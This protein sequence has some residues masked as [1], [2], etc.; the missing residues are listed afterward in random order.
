MGV[1]GALGTEG[2]D[3]GAMLGAEDRPDWLARAAISFSDCFF[4]GGSPAPLVLPWLVV[5]DIFRSPDSAGFEDRAPPL[6]VKATGSG[7]AFDPFTDAR[8]PSGSPGSCASAGASRREKSSLVAAFEPIA[9]SV[10]AS[11]R[12]SQA[13]SS[14]AG[15]GQRA[16]S[17]SRSG[18]S[19]AFT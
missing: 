15:A 4:F 2:V 19:L 17:A 16:R 1:R 8:E 5:S 14:R 10:I 7:V 6:A 12:R 18:F 3:A 13:A 11:A 9:A